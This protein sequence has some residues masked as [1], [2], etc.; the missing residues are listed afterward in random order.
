MS[1]QAGRNRILRRGRAY[2]WGI[3]ALVAAADLLTKHLVFRRLPEGQS[4]P[5]VVVSGFLR[6]VHSENRGGVFGLGQGN[7]A[8]LIFGVAAGALVIWF[9]YSKGG[10]SILVQ[11]ALGLVLAGAVG[12]VF[13]RLVFGHVRDFIDVCYWPGK[14]WPAFNVADS[15]ICI[16]AGC[17]AIYA[18]FFAPKTQKKPGRG[19]KR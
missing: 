16:G 8:W 19:K 5:V 1:Q 14:H 17:L 7:A 4:A 6:L 13:D 18:L 9:A 11:G 10:R 2:F 15:A 3:A 12:N